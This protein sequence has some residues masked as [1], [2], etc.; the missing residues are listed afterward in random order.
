MSAH[1]A[2]LALDAGAHG[3]AARAVATESY[4]VSFDGAGNRQRT[5][6]LI[7]EAS[8]LAERSTDPAV[9][10]FVQQV[11][12]GDLVDLGSFAEG[13]RVL[14][15]AITWLQD[16]CTAVAFELAAVRIYDQIAAHHLGQFA[17]ISS[18]TP[19][20]IEDAL[21][22]GDMW[23][24]TM[25]ATAWALPAW[26]SHRG[27]AEARARYGEVK[28]RYQPQM[29]YQWPDFFILLAEQSLALYE[30]DPERA[31]RL[32]SEQWPRV[33]GA[34]LLR[35]R[36]AGSAMLYSR[37][38]CALAVLRKAKSAS[39]ERAVVQ[40]D[41]KTLYSTRLP[42]AP[43]YAA[44]LE[45]GLLV[46]AGDEQR[47]SEKLRFA[48]DRFDASGMRS[49]AAGAKRRLGELLGGTEGDALVGEADATLSAEGVLDSDSVTE[50]LTP[51]CQKG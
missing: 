34:Q 48:I 9:S 49:Y 10:G 4:L 23:F 8:A 31:L 26:L 17:E 35:L 37:A 36:M 42:H 44:V 43:G 6:T 38:G 39:A 30:R 45:S 21:R 33:R 51:G 13:R 12:G 27:P 25:F 2:R 50:M 14:G 24:T 1:Y 32:S 47:A 40:A 22:R 29:S 28:G 5:L 46:H 16:R 7:G 3:H 19:G 20:L 11:N 15:G 41:M 18:I